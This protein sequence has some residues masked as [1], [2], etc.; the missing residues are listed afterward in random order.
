MK[1]L[2]NINNFR[3]MD[4]YGDGFV[5]D[6]HNGAFIINKY[7]NGEFYFVIA[8]NGQGWDHV[9]V[10]MHRKNGKSIK[11]YP[12]FEEMK[13][14]KEKLFSE[15][16][17]VF[18]LHP[19]EEDYINTH[20]YCLHLWKP[21]D[22]N[23]IVPPLNSVNSDELTEGAYFEHD[24]IIVRIKTGEFDGWQVARVYCFTKDGTPIKSSP[25]WDVMCK[26]KSLVF[27]EKDAAFQFMS[28]TSDKHV[29]LDI[30]YTK[31]LDLMPP[32][33]DSFLVGTDKK[34]IKEK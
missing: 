14:I 32:L 29:G 28:S 6:E 18:Q 7:K 11:K 27:G 25:T 33:P 26:A 10:F 22:C 3:R 20:P 34:M 30:W 4:L 13:M 31:N 19:R 5:G 2:N 21:N 9:S 23:M 15:E 24:G 17:V 12:T 8:S 1:N 16:E